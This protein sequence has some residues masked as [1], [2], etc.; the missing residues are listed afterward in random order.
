[1]LLGTRF[2]CHENTFIRVFLLIT[3]TSNGDQET[4]ASNMEPLIDPAHT[5]LHQ[6]K[7]FIGL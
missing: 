6:F 5:S 4:N 2:I 3:H 7:D 1:M